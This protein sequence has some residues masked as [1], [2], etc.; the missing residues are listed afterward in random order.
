MEREEVIVL[1]YEDIQS[2]HTIVCSNCCCYES[3]FSYDAFDAAEVF[4]ENGWR[5]TRYNNVYCRDC[6]KKK[7][8]Q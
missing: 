6:A 7:L 8:K 4:Y 5:A 2:E 1:L 3:I